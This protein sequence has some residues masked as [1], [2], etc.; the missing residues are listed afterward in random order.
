MIKTFFI[1][2]SSTCINNELP[3]NKNLEKGFFIVKLIDFLTRVY[4]FNLSKIAL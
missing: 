3:N 4:H 2:K 1:K